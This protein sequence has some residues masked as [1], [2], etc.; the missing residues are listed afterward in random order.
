MLQSA[1]RTFIPPPLESVSTSTIDPSIA[2]GFFLANAGS[3]G[4]LEDRLETVRCDPPCHPGGAP[5]TSSFSLL[6]CCPQLHEETGMC[7]FT[8]VWPRDDGPLEGP[9]PTGSGSGSNVE[10]A[11][12]AAGQASPA[13]TASPTGAAPA[14]TAA[15]ARS[16][17][18]SGDRRSRGVGWLRRRGSAMRRAL[19]PARREEASGSG[20]SSGQGGADDDEFVLVDADEWG[21]G[22]SDS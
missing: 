12:C 2:V 8:F 3:L 7:P 19:R 5:L 17:A 15:N 21:A 9:S 16:A 22:G 13:A 14:T 4:D 1:L 18:P 11:H 10:A 6:A 20:G